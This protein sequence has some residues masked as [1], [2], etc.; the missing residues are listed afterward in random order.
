MSVGHL[1]VKARLSEY[2]ALA[3]LS[4]EPGATLRMSE[5][6]TVTNS[7]LSR[8]SHLVNRLETWG[9]VRR[10]P[11]PADG[12]LTNAIL[13]E[14]G[15][16]KLKASAP[17]QANCRSMDLELRGGTIAIAVD[18]AFEYALIVADGALSLWWLSGSPRW[19]SWDR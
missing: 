14:D 12:R 6:A 8:L 11:D 3:R 9:F 7:S 16:S 15:Y 13:T 19:H 10:E 4:E 17:S 1:N 2:V 5:L 18:P